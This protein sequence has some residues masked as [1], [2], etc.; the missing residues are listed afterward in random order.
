M[1]LRVRWATEKPL[2]L[3]PCWRNHKPGDCLGAA[4][5]ARVFA[6]I[7]V[8]NC[9]QE[10]RGFTTPPFHFLET[11]LKP[12]HNCKLQLEDYP[13]TIVSTP[14]RVR[15]EAGERRVYALQQA[16]PAPFPP[17]QEYWKIVGWAPLLI[18]EAA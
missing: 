3:E 4:K 10:G 14:G 9:Q 11:P 18:Q 5:L 12:S 13:E 17:V 6:P 8:N 16:G 7:S 2:E 1:F 15:V